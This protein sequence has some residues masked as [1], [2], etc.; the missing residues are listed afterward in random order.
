[1]IKKNITNSFSERMISNNSVAGR[2]VMVLSV[3][4]FLDITKHL[5]LKILKDI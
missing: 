5:Q 3:L 2:F 4:K 1:M